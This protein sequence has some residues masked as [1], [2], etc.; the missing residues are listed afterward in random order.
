MWDSLRQF[1]IYYEEL[2]DS[3]FERIRNKVKRRKYLW[4]KA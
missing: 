1:Q 3:K 4:Q 2:P